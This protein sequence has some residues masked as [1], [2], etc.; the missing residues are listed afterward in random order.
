MKG[1]ATNNSTNY[2]D[3]TSAPEIQKLKLGVKKPR[4]NDIKWSNP[5]GDQATH[6]VGRIESPNVINSS[7]NHRKVKTT[8]DA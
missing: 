8:F 2:L 3:L 4:G 1:I 7:C 5:Y 6:F